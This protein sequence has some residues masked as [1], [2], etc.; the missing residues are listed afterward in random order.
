MVVAAASGDKRREEQSTQTL[1]V[2]TVDQATV[3]LSSSRASLSTQLQ[4]LSSRLTAL[5]AGATGLSVRG[6]QMAGLGEQPLAGGAASADGAIFSDERVGVF[7]NGSYSSGDKDG[8]A[9]ED[10]LGFDAWGFTAGVD[11]RFTDAFVL[12]LALGFGENVT[13]IDRNGGRLDTKTF[14][15]SA[16]GT[17]FIDD[18]LYLD[19]ILTYSDND[20]DQRRNLNYV[21]DNTLVRQ[22]ASADYDGSQWSMAIGGGYQFSNG[23]WS[24]GPT[25]R[26][27][28]VSASVDG[29]AEQMSNPN[30]PGGGWAARL[31]KLDQES[32]TSSIG[33]DVSRAVSMEWGVLSPQLNLSWIHEFK[34]DALNINGVFVE[35]PN[36]NRFSVTS[37]RPDS[38]YFNARIA[39]A[40]QM[41]GGTSAFLYYN[42]VFGYKN[43]DVDSFGAGVRMAF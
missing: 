3:P 9:N 13:K 27:E 7:V 16:Y 11:Y 20:Y 15:V 8:T 40:A 18:G 26:L 23:P 21:L 36:R 38:D 6:L 33:F 12:G 25:L 30:L 37:D 5:R 1:S 41:A 39:V 2:V 42:K 29:Y 14:S 31:N 17:Y 10:G 22:T 28:Y 35:D 43:L 32:F 34:D 19:G 24:Y 4:N